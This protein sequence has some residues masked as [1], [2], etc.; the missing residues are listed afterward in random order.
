MSRQPAPATAHLTAPALRD[1]YWLASL[2]ATTKVSAVVVT[3]AAEG[4][5]VVEPVIVEAAEAAAVVAVVPV[6]AA[7]HHA[8]AH[9]AHAHAAEAWRLALK[10]H[11]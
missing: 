9:G 7:H 6:V 8:A 5:A 4:G 2:E 11:G 3:A 1:R 10:K